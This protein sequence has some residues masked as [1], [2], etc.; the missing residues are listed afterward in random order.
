MLIERPLKTVHTPEWKAW[1]KTVEKFYLRSKLE[2]ILA[3]QIG[4][5]RPYLD[6]TIFGK[7]FRG[8]LDTGANRSILGSKGWERLNQNNLRINREDET[9][10]VVAN[11]TR[12][13]SIGSVHLPIA[14]QN[15]LRVLPILIVP[16]ISQ[17][18][19]LGMDFWLTMKIQPNLMNGTW[20]FSDSVTCRESTNQHLTELLPAQR[21]ALQQLR[22]KY[23]KLM[24]NR[25]GC[26][27]L[28]KHE[29]LTSAS[30]IK[31]RHYPVSPI[32]QQQ[33]NSELDKM[34]AEGI[35]EPSRSPWSSPVIL[36]R[37]P[38][39]TYRFVV[40]YRKVN[41]V[42]Q[43][44][45][46]PLP[47]ISSILD[48][49]RNARYLSSLDIKSA[50]WQIP[51]ADN[52]KDKTAFT[53]PGRGLFQ[54]KRMPFGLHNSPATWQRLMDRLFGEEFEPYVF[55]YLDDIIIITPSFE[56]H[57]Q[58]LTKIFQ[59]LLETGLTVN[60]EKCQFCRPELKYLGYVV[61]HSG[62]HVDPDKVQTILTIPE[63]K[64]VSEIR[65]FVGV[66]SWYRRFIP[67]FASLTAPLTN[68]LKK[69]QTFKWTSECSDAFNKLKE[70]L[71]SAP[72]LNC[73]N[74]TLPFFVQT[75]A[76]G[77]GIGA[78]L[79]QRNGDDEHVICYAS[80]T[81]TSQERNF[82]T[83]E[84]ECLAVIW[85]IEKFRPYLEGATF[86]VI[87]DHASLV[88]LNNL[89]DP[90]GRLARWAVR[91]QQFDFNIVHRK[92]KDHVLPDLLSRAVNANVN[93]ISLS[94]PIRDAWY[95]EM[96]ERVRTNPESYIRW[97]LENDQLYKLTKDLREED[98][99]LVIP[100]EYRESVLRECHDRPT[101]GH[102]GVYKTIHRVSSLYYWPRMRTDII[103][104]VRK[105][106]VCQVQKVEQRPI[107]G[108][109]GKKPTIVQ[110]WQLISIDFMEFP[111]SKLGNAYL[112]VVVDYFSKYVSLFP[113]R[114]ATGQK[115][116]ELLEKEIFLKYGTPQYVVCDNG[117]QFVSK[118][119]K[120]LANEYDIQILYN[121]KYHPQN[122]PAERTNRVIKTM[123]RSYLNKDH[124]E[125]DVFLSAIAC[126]INTSRN[127]VTKFTPY[128]VNYG[129]EYIGSG[130]C[131]GPVT[132]DNIVPELDRTQS[133][134]PDKYRRI[135]EQIRRRLIDTNKKNKR[136]YDL[137]RR[138]EHFS[139]GQSVWKRNYTLS[140]S[141][142]SY[143]AKLAPK[144][145]GPFIIKNKS[146]SVTYELA[147][148][149]GF[150]H[151]V[152]HVKDL[153]AVQE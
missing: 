68:L 99:K 64:S 120:R 152:W 71:I 50:Y 24:G 31:Q 9:V 58:I 20:S 108:L 83:T 19:I 91:L 32:V 131:F 69:N 75:D 46:Y 34:L 147:D 57:L 112:L 76:S 148:E 102:L 133:E 145:I 59:R 119:F 66:A 93:L 117:K 17:D 65:R 47:F 138:P 22:D 2:P 142:T 53:I 105:C 45:A 141:S 153:K 78:A 63:P 10:C 44:D 54:F 8:L 15:K 55:V 136:Y 33:I 122:N 51:M 135:F 39:K 84:R 134:T 121:A 82:S 37:K 125:W 56:L 86:T 38:D 43:K 146:S 88:W 4:D 23:F 98:W 3:K 1:L 25:L 106:K 100:K 123:I 21:H 92:G 101:A 49:L 110:P 14:L 81:L 96:T 130:K 113:L 89:K 11:G 87:T 30:P 90:I 115:A 97:K 104:Y 118:E 85:A 109:M 74:F 40:D 16:S 52:S 61:D 94:L 95:R 77:Y 7:S 28:V 116:A 18:L 73:P 103:N 6:I 137:R 27:D 13:I 140:N 42:T 114:A 149:D 5:N 35:V 48:K 126:A 124:K 111:R 132:Y 150:S 107:S 151:G 79:T 129:R 128:Y 80:R 26:T 36:V 41:A 67:N 29:I 62:V 70:N 60:K 127:E 12:C 143:A 144:Y 72:I 139:V